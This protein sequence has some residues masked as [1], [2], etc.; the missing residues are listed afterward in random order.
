[1]IFNINKSFNL[2]LSFS[3]IFLNHLIKAKLNKIDP[4]ESY[5]VNIFRTNV[6]I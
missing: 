3:R 5:P 6:Y 2:V 4:T 1:M